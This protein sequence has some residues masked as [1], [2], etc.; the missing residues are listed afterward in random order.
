[1]KRIA[2]LSIALLVGGILS[3]CL[4]VPPE[5]ATAIDGNAKTANEFAAFYSKLIDCKE[6]IE[7][8]ALWAE[9]KCEECATPDEEKLHQKA[10]LNANVVRALKLKEWAE[11]NK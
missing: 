7:V 5:I 3:G 9:Y 1:M 2:L 10:K 11:K 8:T 4:S 6:P